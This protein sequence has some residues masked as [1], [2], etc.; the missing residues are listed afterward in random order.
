MFLWNASYFVRAWKQRRSITKWIRRTGKKRVAKSAKEL[1]RRN[2]NI[3]TTTTATNICCCLH[4]TTTT[5][6]DIHLSVPSPKAATGVNLL[7]VS[8]PNGE[9]FL[10]RLIYVSKLPE[11]S[12]KNP[13]DNP[14]SVSV[15]S[16]SGRPIE[17]RLVNAN[18]LKSISS[19]LKV[20]GKSVRRTSG[21]GTWVH[22]NPISVL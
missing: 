15:C 12:P 16:V 21:R 6:N 22:K 19:A 4:T 14:V 20:S 11:E 13:R 17:E 5:T 8:S 2:K 10:P 7:P 9:T 3:K 18:F 1:P